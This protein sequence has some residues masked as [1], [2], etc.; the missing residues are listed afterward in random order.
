MISDTKTCAGPSHIDGPVQLPATEKYFIRYATGKR[1]GKFYSL[2]RV[3]NIWPKVKATHGQNHGWVPAVEVRHLYL[4]G[5]NRV[6]VVEFAKRSGY[7][8]E[9]MSAVIRGKTQNVQKAKLA[10]VIR[11]LVSIRRHNERSISSLA[12]W[13]ITRRASG[14]QVCPSCAT[15]TMNYTEGCD[16]CWDRRRKRL[17]R[18]RGKQDASVA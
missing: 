18:K 8:Q 2:C 5:C 10:A 16:S 9:G 7:S 13:R 4:E 15:A 1:R 17:E 6:G 3:C 11:E 14:G 12:A